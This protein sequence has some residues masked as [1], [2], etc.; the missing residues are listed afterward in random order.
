MKIIL[1]SVLVDNPDVEL[2]IIK[3]SGHELV[4]IPNEDNEAF[5]EAIKDIDA[6]VTADKQITPEM[7]DTMNNC[8]VIVRQGIG[9]DS[10]AIEKA[11]EKGIIVCNVPDY[12]VQEVSDFTVGL[13]LCCARQI[14]NY[15]KH[16][17]SGI[18]NINSVHEVSKMPPLRRMQDQTIGIVGF[19]RIGRLIATKLKAF[20]AKL[21][22]NDPKIKPE[23]AAEYGVI[24]TD[25]DDLL[26]K[27]DFVSL[28]VPLTD[29]TYHLINDKALDKM[30]PTAY[31][32]NTGRGPIV[33]ETAIIQALK[34]R[35]IA[36]AA[37]DVL[38]NEPPDKDSELLKLD[39]LILTPHAAF[40]TQDSFLELR[41]RAMEEALRVLNG[42]KAENPVN[43]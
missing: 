1:S 29:K 22:V 11:R 42:E 10:I 13:I 19:G 33:D 43:C 24:I 2:E 7:I 5:L 23:L 39:N 40:F 21:L 28:N 9:Y 32:I 31:L 16:T 27:S 15:H 25:L 20:G 35:R 37:L 18:W 17:T 41:T 8:K 26:E 34:E 4:F 30:K 6:I 38:E 14:V 12:C 36:G 3:D